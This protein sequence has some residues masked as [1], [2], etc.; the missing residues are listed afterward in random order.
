VVSMRLGLSQPW[1]PVSTSPGAKR[2][3]FH[4]VICMD[5][6]SRTRFVWGCVIT[7]LMAPSERFGGS[8]VALSAEHAAEE[9]CRHVRR[10]RPGA[11]KSQS[12]RSGAAGHRGD[13]RAGRS[14]CTG[15][16]M[17][18]AQ[19]KPPGYGGP[20]VRRAR[21]AD[22]EPGSAMPGAGRRRPLRPYIGQ[23][24]QCIHT[25]VELHTA[26]AQ[27]GPSSLVQTGSSEPHRSPRI[28]ISVNIDMMGLWT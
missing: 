20:G 28:D 5:V 10:L 8:L 25:S 3:P 24:M 4:V 1:P 12:R 17:V 2:L 6:L 15:A 13:G 7:Y 19:L 27:S 16:V 21:C 18:A 9:T 22:I 11:A 26:S 23:I 14:R